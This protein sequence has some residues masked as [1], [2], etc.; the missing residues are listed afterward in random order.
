MYASSYRE[1]L[2]AIAAGDTRLGAELLE[3]HWHDGMQLILEWIS[4]Q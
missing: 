2:T 3:Q 1:I 4:K